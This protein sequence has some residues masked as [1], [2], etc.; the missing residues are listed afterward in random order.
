M[1]NY[2]E[3]FM[4]DN[5]LTVNEKFLISESTFYFDDTFSLVYVDGYEANDGTL[6]ALLS[7]EIKVEKLK[8]EPWKPKYGEYVWYVGDFGNIIRASY[9]NCKDEDYLINHHS[10][11]K[12]AEEAKDYKWFLDKVDE[13]KKPFKYGEKNC[14][15]V[16]N[17]KSNLVFYEWIWSQKNQGVT[18]FGGEENIKNFIEEV[19][20]ERIKKYM[21]GIWE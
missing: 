5:D 4:K 12:R 17:C 7:G 11:F 15:F 19:E 3:Q 9:Y 10:V 13:Y 2:I 1:T 18:Y 21:F 6:R 8:K 14:Y 16:C 20:G